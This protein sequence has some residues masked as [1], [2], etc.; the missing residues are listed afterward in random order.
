MTS[1]SETVNEV[2]IVAVQR[3]PDPPTTSAETTERATTERATT[4]RATTERA[5]TERATTERATTERASTERPT[6]I[7]DLITTPDP[8]GALDI[9]GT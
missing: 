8:D 9:R 6:T 2:N 4:E 5:T 1:D 3:P 7:A